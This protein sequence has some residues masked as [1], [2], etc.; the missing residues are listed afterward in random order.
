MIKNFKITI[1]TSFILVLLVI[2]AGSMVRMTGSGMGCPDWPKCFG[3]LIPPTTEK[4]V[5]WKSNFDYKKGVMILRNEKFYSSKIDFISS[6][7]FIS[8]NWIEYTKHDY[9]EF[10]VMNTWFEFINRFIGAIAGLSTLIMFLFSFN[11]LKTKPVVTIMSFI[12]VLSM[13]FQAWLG[14]LVV[15]S[16]LSPYKITVHMLMAIVILSLIIFIYKKS[17]VRKN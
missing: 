6:N 4:D 1:I 16:N 17:D 11:F 13:L 9:N 14:K 2:F 8:S 10:S 7:E 3:Y 5:F 12:V 15:D